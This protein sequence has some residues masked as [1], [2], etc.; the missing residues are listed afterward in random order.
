VERFQLI[1]IGDAGM[2]IGMAM[3]N[4][5]PD[6]FREQDRLTNMEGIERAVRQLC[7]ALERSYGVRDTKGSCP[8]SR[9]QQ[10]SKIH[11]IGCGIFEIFSQNLVHFPLDSI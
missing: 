4:R 5:D 1:S 9:Q 7:A 11:G 10:K 3:L 8:G 6:V 2:V